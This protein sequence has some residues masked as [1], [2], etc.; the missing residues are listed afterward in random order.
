MKTE[1]ISQIVSEGLLCMVGL[2]VITLSASDIYRKTQPE[3]LENDTLAMVQRVAT[4]TLPLLF[5]VMIPALTIH[6]KLTSESKSWSRAIVSTIRTPASM[7]FAACLLYT[8]PR[9]R[10]KGESSITD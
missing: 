10:E 2:M 1:D 4:T 3:N 8:S 9:P 7:W 5:T 6:E